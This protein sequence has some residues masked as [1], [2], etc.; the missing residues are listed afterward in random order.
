MDIGA[1]FS[2]SEITLNRILMN[3]MTASIHIARMLSQ[4]FQLAHKQIA[5]PWMRWN[6]V[7]IMDIAIAIK[8][9]VSQLFSTVAIISLIEIFAAGISASAWVVCGIKW[10]QYCE[11]ILDARL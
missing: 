10:Q 6:Q 2:R 8:M 4:P 9:I 7:R 11:V 5:Q 1:Y 3:S